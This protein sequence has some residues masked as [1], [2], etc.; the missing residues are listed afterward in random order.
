MRSIDRHIV[1]DATRRLVRARREKQLTGLYPLEHLYVFITMRCNAKCDH[2]F[3]WEDL[4]VGIP[5]M[6]LPQLERIADTITPLEMICFSGGEPTLRR[7]L[8]DVL[9]LFGARGKAKCLKINTNGLNPGRIEEI[10]VRFKE[11]HPGVGLEFQFSLDGLEETHDRIRG[12]P[13]NFR[14]VLESMRRV[15][16]LGARFP[17]LAGGALTVVTSLNY[18]ELVALNDRLREEIGPDVGHGFELMRDVA[19]TAWSLHPDAAESGVGPKNMELPPREAFAEIAEAYRLILRRS[20][21][22]ANAFYLHNLAQ[23]R[24]VETGREQIKCVTAGQSVGVLYSNGDVAA[25]EFT[26]PFANLA[27]HDFD[28]MALWNSDAANQRRAQLG[29][30]YCIHGCYMGK[31]VEMSWGGIAAM[32]K[33]ALTGG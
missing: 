22:L 28:F 16:E 13:G 25:C 29:K 20:P 11:A 17:A 2:C 26:K 18:R 9:G 4:N 15:K 19:T 33:T 8:V 24:A 3:C 30:C 21:I 7:D 10:A 27:T 31:S 23:L 5:E 12:V 1:A 32:T 6:T 14:K